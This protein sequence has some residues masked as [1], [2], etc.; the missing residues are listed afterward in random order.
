M[1]LVSILTGFHGCREFGGSA[2]FTDYAR[3]FANFVVCVDAEGVTGFREFVEL[4][5]HPHTFETHI[6][7]FLSHEIRE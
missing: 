1:L 6:D 7:I 2:S 4:M 5:I 3:F